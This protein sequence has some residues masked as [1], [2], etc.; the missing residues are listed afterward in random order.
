VAYVEGSNSNQPVTH[1]RQGR[2]QYIEGSNSNQFGTWLDPID[3][4]EAVL[5]TFYYYFLI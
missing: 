2:Q 3:T 1:G 5:N 4:S